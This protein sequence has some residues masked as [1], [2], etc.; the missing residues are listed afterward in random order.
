MNKRQLH[1]II[2]GAPGCG[3]GTQAKQ[4]VSNFGFV[5][6]STGELFRKKYSQKNQETIAFKHAID[7]GGFFSDEMA[8]Q[9]IQDFI[10]ENS[11]VEGIIYDGFPRDI[12]QAKYFRKHICTNPIVIELKADEEQLIDRILKRASKKNRK[13]DQSEKTIQHRMELYRKKTYPVV[14]LFAKEDLLHTYHS[15][16][17]IEKVANQIKELIE[18]MQQKH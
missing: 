3:K 13:D 16:G 1:I 2:M 12:A 9:I 4:I 8:Y 7:K 14:D 15:E 10:S 18:K 11:E 6:L 5:H 17:K